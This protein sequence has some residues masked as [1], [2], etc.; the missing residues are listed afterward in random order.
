MG[1]EV[2]FGYVDVDT[3]RDVVEAEGVEAVISY[4]LSLPKPFEHELRASR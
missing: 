1:R 2:D 4:F 3:A